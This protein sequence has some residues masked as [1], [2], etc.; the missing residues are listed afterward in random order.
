[1][2][3]HMINVSQLEPITK[4]RMYGTERAALHN[5]LTYLV[6]NAT[7]DKGRRQ[8]RHIHKVFFFFFTN[9]DGTQYLPQNNV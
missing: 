6:E 8:T 1:M 9:T 3:D 2:I 4:I 7:L 5:D